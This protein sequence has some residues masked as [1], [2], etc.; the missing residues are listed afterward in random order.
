MLT[1]N[2]NIWAV[3][4][5]Q[6]DEF[7]SL[8]CTG[9]VDRMRTYPVEKIRNVAILGH[10]G[11]GKTSFVEAAL[12][13][14]GMIDRIGRI[15]DGNTTMDYDPEEAR[16]QISINTALASFDW[17]DFHINL[18]DTPGDFDFMGEV[19]EAVRVVGSTLI[20][21][22]GK[23]GHNVGGEKSI[24]YS[25]KQGIPFAFFINHLDDPHS[26]Y[27]GA[28]ASIRAYAERGVVP[29]MLPIYE[30][31]KFVGYVDV[32]GR[33]AYRFEK[34][35]EG[36]PCEMPSELEEALEAAH[37]ALNEAVAESD[38]ALM[39]K[40]FAD[41]P[42]TPDEFISGLRKGL[43][44]GT[45]CP[46]FCGSALTAEGVTECLHQLMV[47]TPAPSDRPAEEATT[48]DGDL[49]EL[50]CDEN[51]PF[52]ALVF[53]TISDPFVGRISL[54]RVYSGKVSASDT[55]YNSQ[56]DKEERVNGLSKMVGKKTQPVEEL[57][58]GDIGAL[59]KLSATMTGDT[60]CRKDKPLTLSGINLPVPSF[61][62]A[63]MPREKGDD[64]KIMAGLNRLQDEDPT[65]RIENNAETHQ[66]LV[67]GLGSQHVDVLKSKL[68]QKFKVEADL[69]E[70][71][72]PYRET[73]RKK[74]KVQGR[75]K[76]QSGGHGQYG[77]VWIEFEP[78]EQED[79]TFET[80]VFGGA[81][82]KNYFP[83]VEKGLREAIREGVLA[84]YPVVH[85]KATL[86]DGSYHDVD[87]S[88]LA[89]KI[90]ANLAYKAGLPQAGPVLLEPISAVKIYVP[91]AQLGDAM[92]D[93]TQKRGRIMGIEPKGEMQ[94]LMAE[95]PTSEMA[96]YAT[97]LRQ[98][99][100]GRGW[101]Q[102]EFARYEQAP[103]QVAD[104][105]IAERQAEKA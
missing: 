34:N 19:M 78:G 7:Y 31:G 26:D 88:E 38:E 42:F 39:E 90:A 102:I 95:V 45:V 63:F 3:Y 76:K 5:V 47:V 49:L 1:S 85:L 103:Q 14:A 33:Q 99:T 93:I 25:R 67:Y 65:F 41:E 43:Y 100:Q 16:R 75:H 24:R 87:S 30:D 18:L 28:L 35:G 96:T 82:P 79:L 70:P 98:M 17:H 52:A 77:D 8:S 71:K 74:V 81:V 48:A 15:S 72:V 51:G 97:S 91:E 62:M 105:V 54:F 80:A 20:V 9:G 94:L 69:V 4:N 44:Q 64:E 58:A 27:E 6:K 86:T 46:V 50:P 57:A 37:N 83:A 29:F 10:I 11:S 2:L 66:I 13:R 53:K 23:D 55:I 92:S 84:G 89:F 21:V 68:K 104:K 61:V 22:S 36:M 56:R 60:L 40:F 101:Y 12:Y 32:L 59:M 73:I